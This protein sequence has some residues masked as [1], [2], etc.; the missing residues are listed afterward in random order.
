MSHEPLSETLIAE[1]HRQGFALARGMFHPEEIDLLRRAAKEDKS[2]DDHAFG[3]DD[4]AGR[5]VHALRHVR[6]L[7]NYCTLGR[8]VTRWRGIPLSQ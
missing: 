4:G 6:A 7:R 2:L 5:V 3:R 1:F 8:E